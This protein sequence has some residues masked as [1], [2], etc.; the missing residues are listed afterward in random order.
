MSS[1]KDISIESI[2]KM[3]ESATADDIIH[4]VELIEYIIER[5]K[6]RRKKK[7]E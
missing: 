3:P 2:I 6:G 7:E 1:L 5:V 4:E